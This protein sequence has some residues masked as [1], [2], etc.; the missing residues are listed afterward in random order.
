VRSHGRQVP[1]RQHPSRGYHR[2]L[3]PIQVI[4]PEI[5]YIV[6]R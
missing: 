5:A 2:V 1:A 6:S 4:R 3:R